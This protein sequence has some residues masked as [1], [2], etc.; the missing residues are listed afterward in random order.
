MGRHAAAA[1]SKAL[2]LL[3]LSLRLHPVDGSTPAAC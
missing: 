1:W 3:R 2:G